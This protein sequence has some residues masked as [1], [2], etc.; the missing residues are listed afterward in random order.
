MKSPWRNRPSLGCSTAEWNMVW[1]QTPGNGL[2]RVILPHPSHIV[3]NIPGVGLPAAPHAPEG[4]LSCTAECLQ[5]QWKKHPVLQMPFRCIGHAVMS[6]LGG[7]YS[8]LGT[9]NTVPLEIK[10]FFL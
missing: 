5:E 3:T 8:L 4:M 10:S 9:S 2:Y 6:Q 1:V 7:L